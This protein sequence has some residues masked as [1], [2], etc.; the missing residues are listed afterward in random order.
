MQVK[1]KGCEQG[2]TLYKQYREEITGLLVADAHAMGGAVTRRTVGTGG[3]GILQA[4][5]EEMGISLFSGDL[6]G[7]IKAYTR[8]TYEALQERG[9]IERR[10]S[11][12]QK[13]LTTLADEQRLTLAGL[14]YMA[15]PVRV[16][17]ERRALEDIQYL[18]D[19]IALEQQNV[20]QV[21]ESPSPAEYRR[22]LL[23]KWRAWIERLA[24]EELRIQRTLEADGDPA[25][26][27][28]ER[29]LIWRQLADLMR[30]QSEAQDA[31][32]ACEE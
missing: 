29:S 5:A 7:Q 11:D 32:R 17:R 24:A 25:D 21:G 28:F 2:M 27:R 4:L 31:L 13:E 14:T 10:L 3:S 22:A 16:G 6:S 26:S 19:L 9:L 18:L 23:D 1:A 20:P 30:A 15:D 8:R 12:R